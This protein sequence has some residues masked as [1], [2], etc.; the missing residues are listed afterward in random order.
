MRW[1]EEQLK[2]YQNNRKI[3]STNKVVSKLIPNK[4]SKYNNKKIKIDGHCFDSIKESKFYEELKLRLIVKDILGF[5]VQPKFI[6]ADNV[7][8]KPD[9]IVFEKDNTR[10]IDIK[11]METQVFKIKKKLFEEKFNLKIEIIK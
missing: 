4:R 5:C 1:T 2:A 9:F 7:S 6:L 10:I 11:G 3:R 8:Y